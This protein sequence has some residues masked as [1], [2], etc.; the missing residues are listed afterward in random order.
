MQF[1]LVTGSA[2]IISVSFSM[3]WGPHAL[4]H[5]MS[6]S[7]YVLH[8]VFTIIEKDIG[9]GFLEL[10]NI[11]HISQTHCLLLTEIQ[12]VKLKTLY[13]ECFSTSFLVHIRNPL[14]SS[15]SKNCTGSNLAKKKA[16]IPCFC[17][18][19]HSINNT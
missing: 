3:W 15:T 18:Q 16:T 1:C 14:T 10:A 2:M 8:F 11:C 7:Y 4:L 9:N 12:L 6:C 5:S 19:I 13:S 17:H